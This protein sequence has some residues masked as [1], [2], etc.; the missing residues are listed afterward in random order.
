MHN[1]AIILVFHGS[2]N[3]Q[4]QAE[5]AAFVEALRS[6]LPGRHVS[7]GFLRECAPGIRDSI[8]EAVRS[9]APEIRLVPIFALTG[10]HIAVDIPEILREAESA[11]PGRRFSLDPVLVRAPGFLDYLKNSILEA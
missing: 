7:H 9:G 2:R 6:S 4:S 8:V 3:P 1:A 10:N 11:H 5:A